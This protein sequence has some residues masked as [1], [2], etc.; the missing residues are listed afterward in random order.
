MVNGGR[1]NSFV[2]SVVFHSL[3][4]PRRGLQMHHQGLRGSLSG[5]WKLQLQRMSGLQMRF[6]ISL[7]SPF[8][9]NFTQYLVNVVLDEM[10]H[11]SCHH[12][13]DLSF[14]H[15]VLSFNRFVRMLVS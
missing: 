7:A 14:S 1:F 3:D 5:P 4:P 12:I 10:F 13:A 8:V 15:C 9:L 2:C 11:I 6:A